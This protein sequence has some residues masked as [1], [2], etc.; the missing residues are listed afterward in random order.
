MGL[1]EADGNLRGM[2]CYGS[3]AENE[4]TLVPALPLDSLL[5]F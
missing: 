4:K 2:L 1:S 5:L 3:I